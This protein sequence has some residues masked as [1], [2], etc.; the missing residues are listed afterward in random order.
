MGGVRFSRMNHNKF[1][2][3]WPPEVYSIK[4]IDLKSNKEISIAVES[5]SVGSLLNKGIS[6]AFTYDKGTSSWE[7][8]VNFNLP[9]WTI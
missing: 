1:K 6:D 7:R 5:M 8:L 9:P 3:T 4:M 2:P